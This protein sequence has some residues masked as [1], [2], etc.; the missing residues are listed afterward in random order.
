MRTKNRKK[1]LGGLPHR[2][3]REKG[4]RR[5]EIRG[6]REEG[7]SRKRKGVLQGMYP[8]KKSRRVKAAGQGKT[9]SQEEGTPKRKKE[10]VKKKPLLRER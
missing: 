6:V 9:P 5:R 8:L 4:G 1:K 2:S 3:T 10:T 7:D